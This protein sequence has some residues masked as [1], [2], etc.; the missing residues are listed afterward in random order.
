VLI[1][2]PS[3]LI[4]KRR[5]AIKPHLTLIEWLF[6]IYALGGNAFFTYTQYLYLRFYF[7]AFFSELIITVPH[8]KHI[9]KKAPRLRGALCLFLTGSNICTSLENY[10]FAYGTFCCINFK[11]YYLLLYLQVVYNSIIAVYALCI[12]FPSAGVIN[13]NTG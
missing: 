6:T 4:K 12:Q 11:Y 1:K 8:F 3:S 2:K 13:S 9:I 10:P 7:S 5:E